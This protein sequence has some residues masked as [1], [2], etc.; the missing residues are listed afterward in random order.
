MKSCAIKN[1]A[2]DIIVLEI[3]VCHGNTRV[4]LIHAYQDTCNRRFPLSFKLQIQIYTTEFTTWFSKLEISRVPIIYILSM[5]RGRK[6]NI[7]YD[8][9]SSRVVSVL[10]LH[11]ATSNRFLPKSLWIQRKPASNRVMQVFY[12]F[13]FIFL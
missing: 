6:S 4:K 3:R 2:I 9:H 1:W 10:H 7:S 13:F 11:Q 8:E 12:L 5:D